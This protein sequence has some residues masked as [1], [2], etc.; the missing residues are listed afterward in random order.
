[1][2]YVTSFDA[3]E[4]TMASLTEA[5]N[6]IPFTPYQ[7]GAMNIFQ[8][9]PV[10]TT[11]VT[12]EERN[13]TLSLLTSTAR[14]NMNQ[15]RVQPGR[16]VTNFLTPHH[17]QLQ[18]VD[19]DDIQNIRAFG[20]ENRLE[21]L[22][23]VVNQQLEGMR[24]NHEATFEYHRVGALKG[25]ILDGDGSTTLYDLYTEFNVTQPTV[26]W[27]FATPEDANLKAN[28]I[29]RAIN[30]GLGGTML[31][32]IVCICASDFFDALTTDTVVKAAYDRWQNGAYLRASLLGPAYQ[33]IDAMN[34]FRFGGIDFVEYRGTIGDVKFVADTKAHAFPVGVNGMYL[35]IPAPANFNETVNTLGRPIYAKQKSAD[36]DMGMELHTQSNVLFLNTR[37]GACVEITGTFA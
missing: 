14:G 4:F 37:P 19:A 1:M 9:R 18:T 15:V 27:N 13:G 8:R 10:R 16:K 21:G 32:G 24:N 11:N 23:E 20:S 3:N 30:A 34:G 12:V 22:V 17:P 26:A 25:T 5:V 6:K 35:E 33:A 2:A 7:I 29:V 36:W 28:E 31:Q